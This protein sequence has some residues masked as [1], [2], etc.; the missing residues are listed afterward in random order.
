MNRQFVLFCNSCGQGVYFQLSN[1]WWIED[2]QRPDGI[3]NIDN[4]KEGKQIIDY[5][6]RRIA[7][8]NATIP[9]EVA[10]DY[11]EAIKCE[12]VSAPKAAV[13]QCRRAMQN[14]CVLKGATSNADLIDQIDELES[15][16]II[17][18][19]LKDMA[20]TIRMIGNWGAHP[21]KDPLRDVT[22]DDAS[23]VLQFT[24]IFLDEIFVTPA[25]IKEL[26]IKK[27]IK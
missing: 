11:T 14:T 4:E 19:T 6:P 5:Y 12:G 9:K 21:Q 3:V 10:G 24:E 27:G 23:E 22:P 15:K 7:H 2:N 17:N 1:A 26:K 16:R 8:L 18:P 25:R 13:T 20:H